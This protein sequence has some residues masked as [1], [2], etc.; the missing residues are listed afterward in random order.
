MPDLQDSFEDR[1]TAAP[2]EKQTR[3]FFTRFGGTRQVSARSRQLL[4]NLCVA[5]TN[6]HCAVA[7][8]C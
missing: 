6:G 7:G 1:S 2:L 3:A 5:R 8:F 4:Q